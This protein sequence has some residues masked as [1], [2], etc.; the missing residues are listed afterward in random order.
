MKSYLS[1]FAAFFLVTMIFFSIPVR[2]SALL[3]AEQGT[4]R[5]LLTE[6]DQS[7][8]IE[9]GLFG[10]Y[11][12]N[13]QISFQSGSKLTILAQK[14]RILTYYEGAVI[15]SDQSLV[16]KRFDKLDEDENGLRLNSKLNLFEGD[17]V[18]TLSEKGMR[19]ILHIG[20]EDYL[21]GVV[22]YEMSESFPIEALKA[23]AI[24]ARSYALKGLRKDR[25]YDLTDN[26]N[27]Q[28]FRGFNKDYQLTFQAVQAT[29]GI[30]L[31]FNDEIARTYYTASNGG[32]TES[33]SNAWT[34][35]PEAYLGVWDDPYD[36]QNP[37]SMVREFRLSRNWKAQKRQEIYF[38]NLLK[39]LIAQQIA[40]LGFDSD[41]T[42][43][44]IEE[45][46][47]INA[48]T[49][50]FQNESRLMTQME[51]LLSV[52]ARNKSRP[53]QE[54]DISLFTVEEITQTIPS[55]ISP[56]IRWGKVEVIA[57]PIKLTVDIFP[58]IEKT[59]ELSINVKDNEIFEVIEE[60]DAFTIRASR[61]GHGVGLS[62]RGA[63]WMAKQ[64][65]K[66]YAEILAFYYPGTLLQTYQTTP[67]TR[68]TLGLEYLT[69]PGPVPT[70]T[71]RPTL[72]PQSTESQPGQWEVV[73]S[74]ISQ[75]SS[76]NLRLLPSITAGVIDQLYYGQRLLV[77]ER[78]EDE[79]LH[80]RAD[81]IQGYV[82]ESFVQPI[83]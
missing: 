21:K 62:Q 45:F 48:V 17:L 52:S 73:I 58:H 40:P 22:P 34:Y 66:I 10:S 61:F 80:V 11:L 46:H 8:R 53:Q 68:P 74:G 63:E 2:I 20:I 83:P 57:Q 18:I 42:Y 26:T 51:F 59:L 12:L 7:R 28:V 23:Q 81:G 67:E 36:K 82:M 65:D 4:V 76:L 50:K 24:A 3:R 60:P 56:E 69:T 41:P 71:P 25:D 39:E 72:V 38:E 29:A 35:E 70:A 78:V 6:L 1:K 64:Y 31:T 15:Q 55:T 75:N 30:V 14:N 79:W 43:I 19:A 44:N 54:E 5:I 32:Q 33:S 37:Q 27:D 77:L 47:K 9:I 16:L 13:D 49:P